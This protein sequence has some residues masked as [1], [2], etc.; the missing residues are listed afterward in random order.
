MPKIISNAQFDEYENAVKE[1][2]KSK[3]AYSSLF[4]QLQ[5][6]L[7]AAATTAEIITASKAE[8]DRLNALLNNAESNYVKL[9]ISPDMRQITP[10][11]GTRSDAFENLFQDGMLDD[12]QSDNAMAVQLAMLSVALDGL[13]QLLESFEPQLTED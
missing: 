1:L 8:I 11:I 7:Q 12:S 5:E 3:N 4:S 6:S 13:Q 10:V 9:M 2:E